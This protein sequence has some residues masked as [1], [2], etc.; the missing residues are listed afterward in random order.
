[1]VRL[2]F[3]GTLRLALSGREYAELPW[4]EGDTVGALL[5]RFQAGEPVPVT[6]KLVSGENLLRAGTIIL[7]NRR[8]ILHLEKLE[9]TVKDGD[10]LAL[11]PP[12]A[13]G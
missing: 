5:E 3:Y 2:Q 8:N 4:R 9:T 12:G 10:V 7:L 1:M 6:G 11:F 13:G